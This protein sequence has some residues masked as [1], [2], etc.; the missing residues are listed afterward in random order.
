[1]TYDDDSL[2]SFTPRGERPWQRIARGGAAPFAATGAVLAMRE[3]AAQLE[4]PISTTVRVSCSGPG[5]AIVC[6]SVG[7]ALAHRRNDGVLCVDADPPAS[8]LSWRLG[9]DAQSVDDRGLSIVE[10]KLRGPVAALDS[11]VPRTAEGLWVLPLPHASSRATARPLLTALSRLFAVELTDLGPDPCASIAHSDRDIAVVCAP[12]T[13][14]AVRS[15]MAR[16]WPSGRTGGAEGPPLVIALAESWRSRRPVLN[17]PEAR[18]Q[19][20][21]LAPGA[22]V[23]V[24]PFDRHVASGARL[25]AAALSEPYALSAVR[26]AGRIL[27]TALVRVG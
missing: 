4:V 8:S 22:V 6:A 26:L 12:A 13:P 24:L 2:V 9:I 25:N 5:S 14:D 18:R 23:A 1:M 27:A 20:G 10:S 15:T 17:V 19:V 7:L 11:V 16:L 3:E 21:D